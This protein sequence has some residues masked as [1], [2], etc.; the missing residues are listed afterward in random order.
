MHAR[1]DATG[2]EIQRALTETIESHSLI[3]TFDHTFV[4]DLF[5]GQG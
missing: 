2:L 4:I 5:T 3:S 1:G